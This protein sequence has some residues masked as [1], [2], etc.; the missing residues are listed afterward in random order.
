MA[1]PPTVVAVNAVHQ[2]GRYGGTGPPSAIDK[3]P[4]DGPVEVGRLGL[5]IDHV[6]NTRHHGGVDKAVYAYAAEDAAWWAAELT[7][8]LPTGAFGEN[9]TTAGLDVTGAVIGERWRVG[10]VLLQVTAPRIPCQTFA[11]FWGVPDLVARFAAHGAPGAY[12]AVLETGS[13]A[14]GDR[15]DVVHRPEHGHTIG[16]EL[17]IRMPAPAATQAPTSTTS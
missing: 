12:L 17:R 16:A 8:E 11:R 15:I 3:R 13:V 5:T 9:L 6:E 2:V 14:A 7:R 1:L 4:V 10:E